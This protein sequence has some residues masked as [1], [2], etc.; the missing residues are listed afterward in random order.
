MGGSRG[1]I[2]SSFRG[3]KMEEGTRPFDRI[4]VSGERGWIPAFAGMTVIGAGIT[5]GVEGHRIRRG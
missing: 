2:D 1:K 3:N 5:G 4:R